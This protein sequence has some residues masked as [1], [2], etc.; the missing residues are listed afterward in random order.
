MKKFCTDL[1]A[2]LPVVLLLLLIASLVGCGGDDDPAD[3]PVDNCSVEVSSPPAGSSFQPGNPDLQTVN[4]RWTDTGDPE[5][6]TI[7]LR[8]AGNLV[9]PIAIG[10]AN[11]G[12]HR[13]TASNMGAANGSD[14]NLRVIADGEVGCFGDSDEFTL[15]NTVGCSFEFTNEFDPERDYDAGDTMPLEWTSANNTGYVDIELRHL[16]D[17]LGLIAEGI[18]DSGSFSWTMDSLHNGS[19][20]VYYLRIV[21]T[22]LDDCYTDSPTFS[23]I[24]TEVCF[25]DV[26]H[27]SSVTELDVGDTLEINLSHSPDVT[28]VDM[29]LYLGN[30]FL[31]TIATDHDVTGPNFQWTVNDFD[32]VG[33]PTMYKIRV[34]NS[35]DQY[36]MGQSETF[37]I[38][39]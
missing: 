29:R 28:T 17:S 21:D 4:I 6:V 25:I 20:S 2:K 10:V 8:K 7:E 37:T 34:I 35:E 38:N 15:T 26:V 18:D 33:S 24:D 13:W 39:P 12:Y 1:S 5:T 9:G 30:Q 16:T 3:P 27:P 22:V 32:N 19:S 23:L 14:Y 36:C 11:S 31:G